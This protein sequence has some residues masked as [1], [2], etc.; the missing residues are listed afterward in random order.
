LGGGILSSL[1][2]SP[3]IIVSP[4]SFTSL[5]GPVSINDDYGIDVSLPFINRPLM[6]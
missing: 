6:R 2:A 5:G 1:L 4:D 3:A